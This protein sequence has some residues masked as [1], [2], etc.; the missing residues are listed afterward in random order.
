M[1][2]FQQIRDLLDVATTEIP[3]DPSQPPADQIAT[4]VSALPS[5]YCKRHS[6][7]ER[8]VDVA[9]TVR[10]ALSDVPVPFSQATSLLVEIACR[11]CPS[12]SLESL[13]LTPAEAQASF[14]NFRIEPPAIKAQFDKCRDF[15]ADPKGQLILVGNVGTGKTHLS[16]ATLRDQLHRGS[17]DLCFVRHRDF[18]RQLVL[19]RRPFP[20][21]EKP[22]KDPM[23]RCRRA[24]LLV[25]DDLTANVDSGRPFEDALLEL[26][27]YRIGHF[28]P[29]VIS[30]NISPAELEVVLG[31]RLLDRFRAANFALLEFGFESKRRSLNSDYLER[32]SKG[33]RH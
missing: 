17:T 3:L 8:I 33:P 1:N 19:A 32:C 28:L 4:S 22:P 6:N 25:Y 31:S 7:E 15:A 12:C 11:P 13:G 24:S 2:F 16:V 10:N 9:A 14:D 21:D 18:L 29:S 23:D 20:F 30:A 27:E 26:F 5:H